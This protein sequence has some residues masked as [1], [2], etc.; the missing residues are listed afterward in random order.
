MLN[1][2]WY[3]CHGLVHQ[4]TAVEEEKALNLLLRKRYIFS[5]TLV[6]LSMDVHVNKWLVERK[7][8]GESKKH[9]VEFIM[10]KRLDL[11]WVSKFEKP[12]INAA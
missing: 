11:N 8:L 10:V 1:L 6:F 3:V 2:K 9:F 7:C 5:C 4:L 12:N